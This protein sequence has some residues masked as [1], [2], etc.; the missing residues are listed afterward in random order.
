MR[1]NPFRFPQK[2]GPH[3]YIQSHGG[4]PAGPVREETPA[5][6]GAGGETVSSNSSLRSVEV[7]SVVNGPCSKCSFIVLVLNVYQVNSSEPNIHLFQCYNSYL[8][9]SE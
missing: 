9:P 2:S 1:R 8:L 4:K 7:D 6:V 5:C 3:D